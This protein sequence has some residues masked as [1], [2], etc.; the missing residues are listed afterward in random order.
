MSLDSTT[1]MDSMF[2]DRMVRAS[3]IV[4]IVSLILIEWKLNSIINLYDYFD[5]R[6]TSETWTKW[7][8]ASQP[9]VKIGLL[10]A[11]EVSP[12]AEVKYLAAARNLFW[13]VTVAKPSVD[14]HLLFE[15]PKLF[16]G[17]EWKNAKRVATAEMNDHL[18][19][20][21]N[22]I[23]DEYSIV[24]AKLDLCVD[25]L[26]YYFLVSNLIELKPS[27]AFLCNQL[28]RVT[29]CGD[30]LLLTVP[31]RIVRG[32]CRTP[33]AGDFHGRNCTCGLEVGICPR[34]LDPQ[35]SST[36]DAVGANSLTEVTKFPARIQ[37][38]KN[39]DFIRSLSATLGGTNFHLDRRVPNSAKWA[40]P[41]QVKSTLP[42]RKE[43][44]QSQESKESNKS[45]LAV[46]AFATIRA[47]M[48]SGA[49]NPHVSFQS[50][51][52]FAGIQD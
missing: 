41:V 47:A 50:N 10:K 5:R 51:L 1:V 22:R 36:T 29:Y 31:S 9:L 7:V 13:K 15:E 14:S 48:F 26:E 8:R 30:P 37:L 3:P 11:S 45:K 33:R 27:A 19:P 52:E 32:F 44:Q 4:F 2:W 21:L 20:P 46:I 49:Q 34:L 17:Q 16:L 39:I 42:W 25:D 18:L 24:P 6:P 23:I 12:A 40:F 28:L 35:T 43:F 38:E